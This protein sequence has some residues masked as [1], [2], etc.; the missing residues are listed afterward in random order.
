MVEDHY[1]EIDGFRHE[2]LCTVDCDNMDSSQ[3]LAIGISDN[4]YDRREV[5]STHAVDT[6]YIDLKIELELAEERSAYLRKINIELMSLATQTQILHD[7]EII[8]LKTQIK[9]LLRPKDNNNSSTCIPTPVPAI[10]TA[11]REWNS[12]FSKETALEKG[13]R[14][15]SDIGLSKT[16][17]STNTNTNNNTGTGTGTS[18]SSNHSSSSRRRSTNSLTS[19]ST[20]NGNG[21]GNGLSKKPILDNDN[22][23]DNCSGSGTDCLRDV[24]ISSHNRISSDPRRRSTGQSTDCNKSR[25]Q[26]MVGVNGD[27]YNCGDDTDMKVIIGNIDNKNIHNTIIDNKNIYNSDGNLISEDTPSDFTV[28]NNRIMRLKNKH[29][30]DILALNVSCNSLTFEIEEYKDKILKLENEYK[31]KI[32]ILENKNLELLSV[33]KDD[34]LE[35]EIEGYKNI[36]SKL[37]NENREL[38][39]ASINDNIEVE[40][41]QKNQSNFIAQ[42]QGELALLYFEKEEN[43]LEFPSPKQIK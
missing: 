16:V 20:R 14:R 22:N 5:S 19:C 31:D 30:S 4:S 11:A 24:V 17:H 18:I 25:M 42:I 43:E 12:Y 28:T 21:N 27:D 38:I 34:K 3:Q 36:I 6:S 39:I 7:R 35:V 33:L 26:C 37:E 13:T 29:E 1:S 40:K 2:I 41:N 32:L 23:N 9:H 10:S 15:S 8:G